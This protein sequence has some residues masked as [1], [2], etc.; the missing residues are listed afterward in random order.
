MQQLSG[1]D[2]SF[3]Y[4]E[5][6]N[7]P[8]HIASLFIYDQSEVAGGVVRFKDILAFFEER[9]HLAPA[10]RRRLAYVPLSLDHPYWIEDPDFDIEY[11]V[12]HIALPKPGD[13][14]QLCIQIAR[15][16]SR[17]L[18]V[19]RPLWEAY[20]I[21]GLG[22][23]P[24]LP[25]GS[26]GI[27]TKT[28][29]AAI[30]GESGAELIAATHDLS[31]DAPP[32]QAE[33][34]WLPEQAP[35]A[36]SLLTR[37]AVNNVRTPFKMAS[38]LAESVPA[39]ARATREWRK[40]LPSRG[41]RVPRTRFNRPVSPHRVVEGRS[42]ALA[43]FKAIKQAVP[44]ATVNDVVLALCGGALRKYLN[45]FG[46]L[47]QESLVA[48]APISTRT[49]D[50]KGV[51]GNKVSQ[52]AVSLRS[53]VEDP[54]ERLEAVHVSTMQSK[55]FTNAIGARLMTDYTQFIPSTTA[56]LAARLYTGLHLANRVRPMFNCVVT[57]VPGPQIP[58]YSVGSR[59]VTTFGMAPIVDG[60]GLLHAVFSYCGTITVTITSCR[61]M[62]PDPE[63]Y[64]ECIQESFEELL[65]ATVPVAKKSRPVPVAK[66][67]KSPPKRVTGRRK[68]RQKKPLKAAKKSSAKARKKTGAKTKATARGRKR[69]AS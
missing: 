50:E 15:L 12:R 66:K 21:E 8:M 3:L 6:A 35:D 7:S 62:M 53:D 55:E 14:R 24:G 68:A 34:Q 23:V 39:I 60:M 58:L 20:V 22:N 26:F 27:F 43:D 40:L 69:A 61:E 1:L 9:L 4:F 17:P 13:W 51:G 49:E 42:F 64:A 11:H 16:H 52:M 2:A 38:V 31:A 57:N 18:D 44:G 25:P 28:H 10:F 41:S 5:T 56:A 30:D 48:M 36:L 59:L 67:S 63:F 37:T 19:S 29:H 47:P 65:V 45:E 32:R 46:E 54:L 33:K